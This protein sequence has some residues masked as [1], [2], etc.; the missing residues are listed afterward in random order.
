MNRLFSRGALVLA[1][2]LSVPT[3][4]DDHDSHREHPLTVAVFGDWPY[5]QNLLDNAHLL[6]NSVDADRDVSLVIHVGDIHSGSMPCTSAGILPPIPTSKPG[7]NQEI[8]FE[9]QQFRDP[10]VYVPGDNEWSD[11]HKSKQSSSGAPL[12]ELASVRQLFFSRPGKTLGQ[13]SRR[14]QT[15]A[16][17]FDP[18]YPSDSQFVE[19]VRWTDSDVTFATFNIPGGSNDDTAP[20]TGIF[21]DP[22]AQKQEQLER[23]AANLRWLQAAFDTARAEHSRA[24]VI[25]LQADMWDPEA[26]A[27]GGAGLDRYTPFVAKLAELTLQFKRP[28]L[29]LNGDTHLYETDQPLADPTSKTG[30]IHHTPAVTNLW[31][32]VVQGSTN[33]PAEWLKLVIDTRKAQPFSWSN[34]PYCADPLGSCQ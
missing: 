23:S 16:Q 31:R 11:C 26:A 14:V 6:I 9:F 17:D 4:A 30:V 7:W 25:A 19:N 2:M 29:L 8:F 33:A 34:V 24:L 1:A 15:Q 27:V 3:F 21:A 32:V 22:D 13:H 18:A 28:V 20:W 10:V 12:K 5:S